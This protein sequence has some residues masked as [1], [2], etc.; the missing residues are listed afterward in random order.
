MPA[1]AKGS[2][3]IVNLYEM[4]GLTH[5]VVKG[6]NQLCRRRLPITSITSFS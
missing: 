6:S 1:V 2:V 4:D 5:N 3:C